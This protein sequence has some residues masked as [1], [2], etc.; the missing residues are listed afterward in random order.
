MKLQV[1][2][3]MDL[4]AETFMPPFFMNNTKLAERV[5][6]DAVNDGEHMFNK[7]PED[8]ALYHVGEWEDEEGKFTNFDTPKSLGIAAQYVHNKSGE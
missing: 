4:K 6:G 3:V 5:F 8:Y 1:F 7:H 2:T